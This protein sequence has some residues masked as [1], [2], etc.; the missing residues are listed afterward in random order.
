M[1]SG[2]KIE[3]RNALGLPHD[4]PFGSSDNALHMSQGARICWVRTADRKPIEINEGED[5]SEGRNAARG[6]W[7]QTGG[8]FFAEICIGAGRGDIA[9]ASQA[10]R[11]GTCFS[12]STACAI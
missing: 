2:T 3:R 11:F 9:T 4:H 8:I 1:P 5:R 7:F 12:C 6:V 10:P